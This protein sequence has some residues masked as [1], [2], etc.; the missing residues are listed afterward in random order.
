MA[1][2]G[3]VVCFQ[4]CLFG[5]FVVGCLVIISAT[6]LKLMIFLTWTFYSTTCWN[7]VQVC[8]FITILNVVRT[9]S[10]KSRIVNS[11]SSK[12]ET[13]LGIVSSMCLPGV[14]DPSLLLA[15]V[16]QWNI[17]CLWKKT[18]FATH[19]SSFWVYTNGCE[20]RTLLM[21]LWALEHNCPVSFI[22]SI[23][24]DPTT[25]RA[26]TLPIDQH[27]IGSYHILSEWGKVHDALSLLE[28]LQ[29]G[30]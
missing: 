4:G 24:S 18:S 29:A 10:K 22:G 23:L 16:L 21:W 14:L 13:V 11:V 20:V 25:S 6:G 28:D 17:Y 26:V 12:R 5:F 3:Y 15:A 27:K 9:Q 30:N 2:L 19:K 7:T 1:S 8:S